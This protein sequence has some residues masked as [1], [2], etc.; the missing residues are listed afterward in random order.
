L[1]NALI[2]V[3]RPLDLA[4]PDSLRAQGDPGAY[5]VQSHRQIDNFFRAQL[6]GA[7]ATVVSYF[8]NNAL[9]VQATPEIARQLASLPGI[10]AVLPFEP[11]YKLDLNLLISAVDQRPVPDGTVVNVVGYP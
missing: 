9:L 10:Q 8:P 6:R 5:L 11:F 4:I 3:S 7:G 1:A 2:D